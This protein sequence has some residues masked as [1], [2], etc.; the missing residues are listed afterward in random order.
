MYWILPFLI[1]ITTERLVEATV[2][3]YFSLI[4]AIAP[5]SSAFTFTLL[6]PILNKVPPV[7]L[8]GSQVLHSQG[9]VPY[10]SDL[11]EQP[12]ICICRGPM[13]VSNPGIVFMSDSQLVVSAPCWYYKLRSISVDG[14]G[15]RFWLFGGDFF[16][17]QRAQWDGRHFCCSPG[18]MKEVFLFKII[19][20]WSLRLKDIVFG[21]N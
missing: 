12:Y 8:R 10:A 1:T 11:T 2:V 3:P 15:L 19:Y 13:R 5:T 20:S 14:E 9:T 7:L 17:I 16:Y 21:I 6:E 18:I 4:A